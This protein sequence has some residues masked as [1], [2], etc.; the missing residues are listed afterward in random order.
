M[1]LVNIDGE[2]NGHKFTVKPRTPKASLVEKELQ[3]EMK[4]WQEKNNKDFLDFM[5]KYDKELA[6]NDLDSLPDDIPESK[7]W[8]EDVEFR[9]SRYKKMADS[10]MDFKKEPK[11][12]L[13][14]SD[15]L[16]ISVIEEAFDFF[17]GKRKVPNQNTFAR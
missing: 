4:E 9:A 17:V 12:S 5:K 3:K 1:R 15:D 7:D 14:K 13:W 6:D 10:A 8:I 16:E 2:L 11:S